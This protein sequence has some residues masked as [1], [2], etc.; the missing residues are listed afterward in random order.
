[1]GVRCRS[2]VSAV[3]FVTTGK[4]GHTLN[5]AALA[6]AYRLVGLITVALSMFSSVVENIRQFGTLKAI[7]ATMGD[8]ARLL[9][10]QAMIYGLFGSL[11]GLAMVVGMVMSMR[12]PQLTPIVP[13]EAL[14]LTV[15]VMVG[16][17]LAASVLALLKLRS[18]EP[19]MVF[20]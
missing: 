15:V 13:P 16:V 10:V 20:R 1:M 3:A 8:L 2:A 6:R 14:A 5:Q 17:C 4:D 18:V 19:G 12:N 9:L 7:G 11:L